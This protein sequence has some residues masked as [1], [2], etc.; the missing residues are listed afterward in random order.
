MGHNPPY[1]LT[2][3]DIAVKRGFRGTEEEWLNSLTAFALVQ[4]AGYQ[5]SAKDW[6]QDLM[7]PVPLIRIGEVQTLPGGSEATAEIRGDRRNP[8]LYLGIPRGV[9]MA[10]ALP[11]VGGRMQGG[12]NMAGFGITGLKDPADSTDAVPRKYADQ[13]LKKDGTEAMTG[14]LDMGGNRII[15]VADPVDETD[16]V[17][18]KYVDKK[19]LLMTVHLKADEWHG[20]NAPYTQTVEST[21]IRETDAPHWTLVCSADLQEALAEMEDF[22]LVDLLKTQEGKLI[23]SCLEEKPT[24]DLSVQVEVNR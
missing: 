20:E 17:A 4:A 23:F 16:A 11:L 6:L 8:V 22:T 21:D 1:Y 12:I 7:E 19:H 2:A 5:G 14:N 10:D 3:Y 24:G 13:R 15:R 18:K 9:G